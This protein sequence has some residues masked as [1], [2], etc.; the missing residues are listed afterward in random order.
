[1]VDVNVVYNSLD[2]ISRY[3]PGWD[4]YRGKVFSGRVLKLA[5]LTVDVLYKSL[6][7]FITG[8]SVGPASDG[9]LDVEVNLEFGVTIF[10][11]IYDDEPVTITLVG[12]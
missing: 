11:V 1:M 4:L 6:D 3:E 2:E 5:R 12:E 9:S 7:G 8:M 10:V